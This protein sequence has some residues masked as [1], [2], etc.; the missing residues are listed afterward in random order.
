MIF[1]SQRNLSP[2]AHAFTLIELLIS[3]AFMSGILA[4]SYVCLRAA[5]T[6][7]SLVED[8][9][10]VIQ[11]ARV[12]M[13]LIATDLRSAHRISEQHTVLGLDRQLEGIEADTIDFVTRHHKPDLPMEAD[14]CET[15]YFVA[16]NPQDGR[17]ALLRRRDP[18]PDD[19]PLAGGKREIL[20]EDILGLKFEYYDGWEWFDDWGDAQSP[21]ETTQ[22]ESASLLSAAARNGFPEAIRVSLLLPEKPELNRLDKPVALDPEEIPDLPGSMVFQTVVR[23]NLAGTELGASDSSNSSNSDSNGGQA[24]PPPSR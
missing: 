12:V 9:S 15:S 5:L 20:I 10:D 1:P 6:S 2:R 7:R 17:Y 24:G 16:R 18:L 23:L 8:R 11:S 3:V 21:E 14:Y 4:A 13:N 19:E 22:S